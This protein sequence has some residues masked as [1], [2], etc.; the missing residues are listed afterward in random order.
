MRRDWTMLSWSDWRP[1]LWWHTFWVCYPLETLALLLGAHHMIVPYCFPSI[2]SSVPQKGRVDGPLSFEF[3]CN[4]HSKN[5]YI[6][7][8]WSLWVFTSCMVEGFRARVHDCI[9]G[10]V[11]TSIGCSRDQV[12]NAISHV[13][14]DGGA[15]RC[16]RH[17]PNTVGALFPSVV[18]DLIG[19]SLS[20]ALTWSFW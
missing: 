16:Y 6:V 2:H 7:G 11:E 14:V 12:L 13:F 15:L 1:Q 9:H 17:F 5:I 4:L 19:F 10:C 18:D 20:S 8:T 3:S